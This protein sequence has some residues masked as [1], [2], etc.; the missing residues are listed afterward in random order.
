MSIATQIQRI[1]QA[2]TDIKAAINDK[3]VI[4]PDNA[5]IDTYPTYVS[6]ISSGSGGGYDEQLFIDMIEGDITTLNIPDGTTKI[7]DYACYMFTSLTSLIIPDSVVSIGMAAFNHCESLREITIPSTVTT[8]EGYT[9]GHCY[10]LTSI[11]IPDTVREIG[12]YAFEKCQSLTDITIPSTLTSISN[13][14]FRE[15]I[16]LKEVTIPENITSIGGMA[17][18]KCTSLNAITVLAATPPT[19]GANA[20]SNTNNCPIY[21]PAESVNS[22]K[23]AS[24]W[25][26]YADRI[27]AIT[28]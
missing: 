12:E 28:E 9:F 21:V 14:T 16:Y 5:T 22:Y 25:I 17:F 8:I 24:N 4:I 7:C 26:E 11:T 23:N 1:Q 18:Y 2:K 13:G 6:Q 15:C 10:R 27:F 20:F 19:L 3:G